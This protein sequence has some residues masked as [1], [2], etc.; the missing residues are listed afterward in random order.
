MNEKDLICKAI[1][2]KKEKVINEYDEKI[3]KIL[4]ENNPVKI[5]YLLAETFHNTMEQ[6]EIGI[7][8]LKKNLTNTFFKE[9]NIENGV[10]YIIFS[11]KDFDVMFSKSLSRE[12][13]I[14][15]KNSSRHYHYYNL[16]NESAFKLA[17]LIEKYLNKKSFKNF[18]ALV[19]YN[20]QKRKKNL[21]NKILGYISTYKKCNKEL[22]D[23]IR[24]KQEEDRIN[25]IKIE[26]E[27]KE[28]EEKQKYAKE[29][30]NSLTD[31]E[32]F[33]KAGWFISMKGIM[34]ENEVISW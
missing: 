24:Q 33:K 14:K 19:D 7:E 8:F 23:K 20:C 11:N 27:N 32:Q 1:K 17:D 21:I 25:K 31:L 5:Y 29:F 15:F 16:V 18:K 13:K 22:L 30:I 3:N 9:A 6:G 26:K 2:D 4:N 12:I 34:N 10:N 28:F